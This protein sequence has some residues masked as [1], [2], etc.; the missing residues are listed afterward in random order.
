MQR[1]FQFPIG[2]AKALASAGVCIP[3][4]ENLLDIPMV[5]L[6]VCYCACVGGSEPYGFDVCQADICAWCLALTLLMGWR[7]C[8]LIWAHVAAGSRCADLAAEPEGALTQLVNEHVANVQVMPS[9]LKPSDS[10]GHYYGTACLTCLVVMHQALV[11]LEHA[12]LLGSGVQLALF[13]MGAR[14]R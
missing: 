13:A 9:G 5:K 10:I 1:I 7:S 8:A 4:P 3:L 2:E 6:G 12:Q 14:V 11:P